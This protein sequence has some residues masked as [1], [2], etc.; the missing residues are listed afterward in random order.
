MQKIKYY[1]KGM[2]CASCELIIEKKIISLPGV[3]QVNA[4]QTD[5]SVE[6]S[7]ADLPP[8]IAELNKLFADQKYI[9]SEKREK[10]NEVGISWPALVISCAALIMLLLII[11]KSGVA[12]Y[13][14]INSDSSLFVIFLFGLAAGLSSCA[15]LIGGL[16][17]SMAKQWNEIYSGENSFY[18]R[19]LPHLLFNAG[20]LLSY[21][22]FGG[23]L[24]LIGSSFGFNLTFSSLLVAV[25]SLLMIAFGLNMLGLKGFTDFKLGPPKFI[26]RYFTN[27]K[28]FRGK[29]MPF[30]LGFGT[31]FIPCGFTISAQGVAL[32][33][34]SFWGGAGIMGAF[35]LGTLPI[36]LFIGLS[37]VKLLAKPHLSNIFLKLAGVAVIFFGF[38]NI[39]AQLNVLGL[40]SLSNINLTAPE[41]SDLPPVIEGQQQIKMSASAY[42]YSP[43]YFKVRAGVPV[44]FIIEDTGTSGCTNAVIS[45]ELW[46]QAI[47]LTPGKT[48][49]LTFTP[50]QPGIYKFSCWMGMVS[51]I[52]EVIDG[53]GDSGNVA[54][55]QEYAAQLADSAGSC[56]CG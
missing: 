39:N 29:Y 24:G 11:E 53:N 48:S 18:T 23:L 1:V 42:G 40:P 26:S 9:F 54:N 37:S 20:R 55:A 25:I 50:D 7:A 10:N 34:G 8:S 31:F 30:L 5:N 28:N 2:H 41:D 15:A 16:I 35:A 3:K 13:I 21:L 27:E 32:L 52:I 36:L 45:P 56:G 33:S 38:F 51:G 17:L 4:S 12:G 22:L 14:S 6:I 46:D 49:E 47:Q 44:K 43:N 19:S